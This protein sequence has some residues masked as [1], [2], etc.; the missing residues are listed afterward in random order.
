M[1]Q[2]RCNKKNKLQ[3]DIASKMGTQSVYN[4]FNVGL[5]V[6]KVM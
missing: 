2:S 5:G 6:T 1:T 3:N 4:T